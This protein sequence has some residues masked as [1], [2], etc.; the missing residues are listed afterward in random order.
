MPAMTV[1]N[2]WYVRF[3]SSAALIFVN[4]VDQCFSERL[5]DP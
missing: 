5:R 3:N 2:V 1:N 4:T